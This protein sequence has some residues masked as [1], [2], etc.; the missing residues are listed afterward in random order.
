MEFYIGLMK[1][2]W[3]QLTIYIINQIVLFQPWK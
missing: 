2:I 1:K 3:K